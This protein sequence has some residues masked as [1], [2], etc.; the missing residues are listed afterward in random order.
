MP[1][2][3]LAVALDF[4]NPNT[5]SATTGAR[6][7]A[8][9]TLGEDGPRMYFEYADS[10]IADPLHVSP[11]RLPVSAGLHELVRA[12]FD[13][14]PGLLADSIPD[15]WGRLVQDRAFEAQGVTAGRVRVVDRLSALGAAGMGALV[16]SPVR[17]LEADSAST[18]TWP[19]DLEALAAQA[20]RVHEGSAE[21]LL[22]GMRLGGGP[23]GGARPKVLAGM[24]I[25]GEKID[26]IAGVTPGIVT[27]RLPALPEDY[28]PYL[29]KFGKSQDTR[30]YG[31][32]V[33]AVE[34]AYA[35][36]ARLAGLDMPT[37]HLLTASDGHRHFAIERFDRHGPGGAGR[38]HMHTLGGLLHASH[39]TPSLD[40]DALLGATFALTQDRAQLKEAFRRAAFNVFAFNRDD[41]ARNFSFLMDAS[42]TWRLAPAYDLTYSTGVNGYH[43]IS[44]ADESLSPTAAHLRTVAT[45]R[46]L[47][48]HDATEVIQQVADAVG[49]WETI[50]MALDIAPAVTTRLANAFTRTRNDAFPPD[51]TRAKPARKRHPR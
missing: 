29:I 17:Q 45:M 15:G 9:G 19:L 50:A 21:D 25:N 16:F 41:H 32:D 3:R 24:R 43:S 20:T 40:Y 8:V 44:V 31:R 12:D 13:Y 35:R 4:G 10:F 5:E 22:P 42:G 36:M 34:E 18:D 48:D 26:L 47:S 39:R 28:V 33:G 38:F 14:V 49:Q 7:R 37:T 11:L 6:L 2:R 27:G 23:P 51:T 30:L 46:D 1:I